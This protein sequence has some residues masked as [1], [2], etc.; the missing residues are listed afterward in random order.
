MKIKLKVYF[1]LFL[2]FTFSCLFSQEGVSKGALTIE[3]IEGRWLEEVAPEGGFVYVFRSDS[4]FFRAIDNH[5]VLL[6]NVSGRYDLS[7]DTVKVFYQDLS[8]SNIIAPNRVF[9]MFLKVLS[10]SDDELH[11]E[12]IERNRTSQMTLIRQGKP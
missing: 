12:K 1:S 5:D 2:F 3:Q 11:F 8:P 10:V 4:S 9:K 6:F 7:G